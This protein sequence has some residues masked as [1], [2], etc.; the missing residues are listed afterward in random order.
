MIR[1]DFSASNTGKLFLLLVL[2][3]AVCFIFSTLLSVGVVYLLY[4]TETLN[5]LTDESSGSLY[6]GAL[7]WMQGINHAGSFLVTSLLFIYLAET[8]EGKKYLRGSIPDSSQLWLI[9]LLILTA[10]P[11]IAYV[12][13]WNRNLH[14]PFAEGLQQS[15]MMYEEKTE[16]II[17]LMLAD[18]TTA[19]FLGNLFVMALLPAIGEEFLFRGIIQRLF[20]KWWG[21]I[22]VAIWITALLF[23]IMH[24]SF[25]G[26]A[27]RLMLGAI[28]G[29]LFYFTRNIWL[30]VIAHFLNNSMA[31]GAAFLEKRNLSDTHYEDF[32]YFSSPWINLLSII[33][34]F[35]ILAWFALNHTSKAEN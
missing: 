19:G 7:R 22:H 13:E 25:S 34:T 26:L 2:V 23:S 9:V 32:G 24:F 6:S 3:F 27:P 35:I 4:G 31:L 17:N 20:H 21:N 16:K 8:S 15:L 5:T 30:P 12:Y 14:L 33:L 18:T 28:F 29:Y 11:W 10:T 1:P